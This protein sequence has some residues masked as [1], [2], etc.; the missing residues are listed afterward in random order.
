MTLVNPSSQI[1]WGE[2]GFCVSGSNRLFSYGLHGVWEYV[3]NK[4]QNILQCSYSIKGLFALN[5]NYMIACGEL[6][7]MYFYDGTGWQALPAFDA[8]YRDMLYQ[9]AWGDGKELFVVGYT[10]TDWPMKTLV[11]HGK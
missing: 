8:G 1:K 2:W 4:W 5:D 3:N 7:R 10:D 9:A 6:G 11:F